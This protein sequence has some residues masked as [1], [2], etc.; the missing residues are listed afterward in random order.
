M[1]GTVMA[2]VSCKIFCLARN[3]PDKECNEIR[4]DGPSAFFTVKLHWVKLAI[5]ICFQIKDSL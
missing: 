5:K 4:I 3:E 2:A 1:T